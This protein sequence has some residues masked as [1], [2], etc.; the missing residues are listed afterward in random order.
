MCVYFSSSKIFK[1]IQLYTSL[2]KCDVVLAKETLLD[3]NLL[4]PTIQSW[5]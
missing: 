1:R 5:I 3:P 4:L 2:K